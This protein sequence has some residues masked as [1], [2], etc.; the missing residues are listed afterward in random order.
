MLWGSQVA[1]SLI[2][3][4]ALTML[5]NCVSGAQGPAFLPSLTVQQSLICL[6][7]LRSKLSVSPQSHSCLMFLVFSAGSGLTAQCSRSLLSITVVGPCLTMQISRF[8]A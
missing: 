5:S 3:L 4:A 2:G 7:A 1:P 6:R 8:T